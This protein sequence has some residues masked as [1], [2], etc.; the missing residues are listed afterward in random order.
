MAS[1]LISNCRL[2]DSSQ[3]KAD[4]W[5]LVTDG[6]IERFGHG[7]AAPQAHTVLDAGGRLLA[8]GFID[9]HIQG[10]GGADVLDATPEALATIAKTCARCGVTSYLAT[11][12][13]KPDQDNR[14][15]EVVSECI[16]H[17]LG[18]ARLRGTHLEGPFISPKKRG[19]I[20][21]NCLTN[22][23]PSA[24]DAILS[25]TDDSLA[26]MTLAPELSGGLDLVRALVD[27]GVVASLGHTSATYE[28]TLGGFDAGINHVTHLF[29]AMPSLHHRSPGPLG[30][31]FERPDVTVQVIADGVHI[32]PSVVRLAYTGLGPDR[33]VTIT[34]GMQALGLPDGHYT[35]NGIPYEARDGAA[36]YKDGTLIGTALGLNRILARLAEFTGCSTATAIRTVTENAAAVLGIDKKT[37]SIAVGYDADLVVLEEDLS[38]H[39]TVVA[40]RVVHQ[41]CGD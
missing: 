20:Q 3:T 9:V 38:V 30:A 24:L 36:R 2:Y 28:E 12:V 7:D 4:D 41:K 32:H 11:T 15:L 17:D 27:R 26:M 1:L 16:G 25:K 34:D 40:G 39:T 18:G 10:A 8:P 5:V 33:F 6:I 21:P 13:Y 22:P 31:I 14:H 35:Y 37:G 23:S 19:M 29:N